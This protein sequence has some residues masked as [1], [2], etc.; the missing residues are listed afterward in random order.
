MTVHVHHDDRVA[1]ITIDRPD[2]RNAIDGPTGRALAS[3]F[4]AAEQDENVWAVVLTGTGDKAFC[5]GA[6][7]RAAATGEGAD[8]LFT[9]AG[10]AGITS[11]EFPKP[12]I[13]AVNG[14]ALAGGFEIVLA[15]DLVVAA[16]HATFGLP[17]VRWGIVAGAGGLVRLPRRAP[18][19]VTMELVMTGD[20]IDARRALELGL[21]NRVVPAGHDVEEAL[22][23]AQ[24]ICTRA[25]LA[26][27]ASKRVAR[28]SAETS[29]RDAWDLNTE[30]VNEVMRSDD[31][32]EG[33][34]AF[35]EKRAPRWVAR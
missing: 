33:P 26:V 8:G 35:A 17:E 28:R 34:R 1:V 3:A 9:E 32:R 16:E 31:A 22:A 6:D 29:E 25:P 27:R 2:Q 20:Q 13:A 11:R 7:L 18:L 24:R 15:C 23:L 14:S 12:L 21:V 4:D 30:V 10:F 19:A 5:A